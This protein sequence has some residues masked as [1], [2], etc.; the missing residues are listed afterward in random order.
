MGA[1]R[2]WRPHPPPHR[3]RPLL[4][5]SRLPRFRISRLIGLLGKLLRTPPSRRVEI[6]GV[7]RLW[8]LHRPLH[9]LQLTPPTLLLRKVRPGCVGIT[10]RTAGLEPLR[11]PPSRRLEIMGV[12]RSWRLRRPLRYL[13]TCPPPPSS[14]D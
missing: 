3:L 11:T 10:C 7:V 1:A 14:T 9:R 8:R 4:A 13:Q 5:P 2:L 6:V 12:V